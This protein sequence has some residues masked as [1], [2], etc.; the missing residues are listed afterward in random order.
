VEPEEVYWDQLQFKMPE[1][2]RTENKTKR[3]PG[4]PL[5]ELGGGHTARGACHALDSDHLQIQDARAG[6]KTR[7]GPEPALT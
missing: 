4:W 5:E 1:L 6:I 7:L 2:V 3:C